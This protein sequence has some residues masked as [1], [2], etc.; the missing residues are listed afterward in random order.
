M[1]PPLKII[2][3]VGMLGYGYPLDDFWRG[4]EEGVDAIVIDSGS[5]DNGPHELALGHSTCSRSAYLR[6]LEP[7]L[8]ASTRHKIPVL[9]GSAGGTGTNAHVDFIMDIVREIAASKAYRLRAASIYADMPKAVIRQGLAEGRVSPCG[10]VPP[11]TDHDID[12]A[13]N[14]VAQMGAEPFMRALDEDPGLDIIVAG[15]A[16]DPAPYA[17]LCLRCGVDPG[18]A[19]HMGKIMEC[20]GVCAEPKGRVI[21]ATVRKDSFDLTPMSPQERCTPLSVAAHTLYEKSRADLLAGPGGTLDLGSAVYEAVDDR[22]VRVRSSIF[23]PSPAYT[24]KLEGAKI[25][26]HRT[27]FIGGIRDPILI[28]QVDTYLERVR[29]YTTGHHASLADGS[30]RLVFHVYGKNGV[31]GALEPVKQFEP[32]EL[33]ILAEAIGPT[34]EIANAICDSARVACLHAPYAGQLAT[35]G[36]MAFPLTPLENE[37]GPV[38]AFN[39]Y[40]LME[41]ASPDALFPISHLEI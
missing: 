33:C 40:H 1:S 31:V 37:I 10:P 4:I 39:L 34:R 3:P 36:N 13:T 22:T 18:I 5:T 32:L 16:Y 25:V 24:V 11:L 41:V 12:D 29:Q 15:R 17:A 38:C 9:I 21:V 28:A 27:I 19:W 6:D 7:M 35:G 23:R 8:A 14:I 2:T 20:G 26:G 30:A